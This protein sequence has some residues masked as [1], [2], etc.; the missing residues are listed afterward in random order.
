MLNSEITSLLSNWHNSWPNVFKIK[1][2][3]FDPDILILV[4]K[5]EDTFTVDLERSTTKYFKEFTKE[6]LIKRLKDGS[7]EYLA[8]HSVNT[9]YNNVKAGSCVCGAWAT[10]NPDNHSPMCVLY[11]RGME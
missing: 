11:K 6:Q 7:L 9:N 1:Y 8:G 4:R 5:D 2:T 3:F 10:R